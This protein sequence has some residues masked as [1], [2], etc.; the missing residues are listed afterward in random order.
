MEE[1]LEK[2]DIVSPQ[3]DSKKE[4]TALVLDY[5]PY[6]YPMENKRFPVI[7]AIGTKNLT[8]LQI[9]PR[10]GESIEVGEDLYI[11]DGKRDK[12]QF[13]Q[14][15]LLRE[16]LTETAKE[17]LEEF[18]QKVVG[19]RESEYVDFFNKAQAINTRL[20]QFELLPGFGKKHTDAIL[21]AKDE[22][23]FESFEDIKTRVHNLP[24]PNTAIAKRIFEELTEM[25]RHNLFIK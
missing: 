11:G 14:G 22:K 7:Q 20:H 16:K 8:L 21:D 5:L 25:Q 2:T 17:N 12:V 3:T 24:D 10:K 6:G 19:E 15:R 18:L 1:G 23:E 9:V 13:I 4:E